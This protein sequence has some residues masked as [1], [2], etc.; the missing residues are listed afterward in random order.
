MNAIE[1]RADRDAFPARV[2]KQGFLPNLDDWHEEGLGHFSL[3]DDR[4]LIDAR[5]GGYTAFHRQPLP[6]DIVVR[7][8][9]RSMPPY[10]QNNFNLISHCTPPKPGWP[11]VEQGRY[12]GYRE[13]DNYIVTFV[14]DWEEADRGKEDNR[15]GRV[16]FRRNPGFD[17]TREQYLDSLYGKEYEITYAVLGGRLRYYVDGRKI[18]DWQDPN[19]LAGGYLGLRTFC[20]VAEY[21][22]LV[23]AEIV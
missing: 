15:K 14:G 18:G 3:V 7:Y 5:T 21:R 11:I 19:P 16:R 4:M 9:V 22:D 6:A 12:A 8:K 23:I 2:I 1:I 20:T 13:F 10:G 17:L